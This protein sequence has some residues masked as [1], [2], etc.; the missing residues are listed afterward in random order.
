MT[1]GVTVPSSIS[2][3]SWGSQESGVTVN[4][5]VFVNGTLTSS[6]LSSLNQWFSHRGSSGIVN[7]SSAG[8]TS[9]D[10]RFSANDSTLYSFAT[11]IISVPKL[12]HS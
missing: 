6:E 12:G 5:I 11:S 4:A 1:Y 10:S 7:Y 8:I 9:L 2:S 3:I